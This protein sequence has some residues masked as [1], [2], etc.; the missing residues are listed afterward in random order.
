MKKPI[1]PSLVV[2]VAAATIGVAGI[3][4]D[5]LARGDHGGGGHGAGGHGH[6]SSVGTGAAASGGAGAASAIGRGAASSMRSGATAA[7][8]VRRGDVPAAT[9][10]AGPD[11]LGDWSPVW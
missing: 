8:A 3:T 1:L 4:S 6:S 5:A 7:H 2:L 10:G 11:D 9:T